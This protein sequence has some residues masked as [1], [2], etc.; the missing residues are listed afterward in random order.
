MA[1]KYICNDKLKLHD[2]STKEV[3]M[4]DLSLRENVLNELEF[5]PSINAAHIGVAVD[6]GVVTLSGHVG[7][8]AEKLMAE[9][10][11]QRV[12]GVRAIAQEIDVRWPSD[13]KTND[14]EIAQRA[15]KI[16]EWDTTVPDG[17]VQLK[18]QKGWVTLSGEVPWYFQRSAA[19]T[20]VRKLTGVIGIT[21]AITVKPA[22]QAGDIKHRI[23]DAL[24]RSAEL[25]ANQIRVVVSGGRVTL[26]GKVKAWH[27]R[28]LAERAA[29]AAPGVNMVE[30]H[31]AVA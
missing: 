12:K 22:V 30:D 28:V 11:V 29:W 9:R 7:S 24:K 2:V 13:Q 4:G 20:A 5:E 3:A 26:E 23:E 14:D 21:N 19:E 27:E 15:L 17:K 1:I 10:V 31:L 18:V 25:E 16:I 8:Y 6:N